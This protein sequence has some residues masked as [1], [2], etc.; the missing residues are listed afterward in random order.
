MHF[1]ILSICWRFQTYLLVHSFNNAFAA[2][3]F[4]NPCSAHV[5]F[6]WRS[7]MTLLP[8]QCRPS[9]RRRQNNYAVLIYLKRYII[10]YYLICLYK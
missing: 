2:L 4:R 6:I 1:T 3:L 10:K 7:I 8:R 5:Q 9:V